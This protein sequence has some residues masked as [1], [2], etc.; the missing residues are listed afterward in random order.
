MFR[1]FVS[2]GFARLEM[3]QTELGSCLGNRTKLIFYILLASDKA[4]IPQKA[5][6]SSTAL[7]LPEIKTKDQKDRPK[8]KIEPWNVFHVWCAKLC[9]KHTFKKHDFFL[10]EEKAK[11]PS[12]VML[13]NTKKCMCAL[14]QPKRFWQGPLCQ[15]RE[16]NKQL[17]KGPKVPKSPEKSRFFTKIADSCALQKGL[18]SPLFKITIAAND[19]IWASSQDCAYAEPSWQTKQWKIQ[20]IPCTT[21]VKL[22]LEFQ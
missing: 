20:N 21:S 14:P 3:Q 19:H 12:L 4:L 16:P 5:S 2:L 8:D 22:G 7:G 18:F 13:L 1:P 11:I 9:Q 15:R 10:K 6:F 17:L